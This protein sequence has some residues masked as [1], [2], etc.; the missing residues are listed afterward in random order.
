MKALVADAASTIW[1][2]DQRRWLREKFELIATTFTDTLI[3]KGKRVQGTVAVDGTATSVWA[4]AFKPR[5]VLVLSVSD[6]VTGA[7]FSNLL[8]SWAWNGESVTLVE[9]GGTLN[10]GNQTFDIFFERA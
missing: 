7:V 9:F 6:P 8:Y 5:A 4:C 1:T 2:A 10:P 3:L